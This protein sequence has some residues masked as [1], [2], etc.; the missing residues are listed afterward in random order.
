MDVSPDGKRLLI[1]SQPDCKELL[2]FDPRTGKELRRYPGAVGY[3]AFTPDGKQAFLPGQLP[4]L[5]DLESGKVL[6][7]FD[8]HRQYVRDAAVS[9]DGRLGLSCSGPGGDACG[10]HWASDCS[11]R[12]W[13]LKTGVELYRWEQGTWTRW[14][15]CFTPDSKWAVSASNDGSVSAFDV[16]TGRQVARIEAP[17]RIVG[18]AVSPD[19]KHVVVS[20]VDGLLRMYALPQAR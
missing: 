13:D 5:L 3:I 19:G 1:L 2:L 7:R 9:P 15:C 8:R 11:L 17:E 20:C 16:S 14:A 12:L 18:V 6:R 4:R 10:G